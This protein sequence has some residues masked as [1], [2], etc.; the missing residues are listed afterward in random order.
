MKYLDSN[1]FIY[2]ALYKWNKAKRAREILREM[3]NGKVAI[4]SALTLSEIAQ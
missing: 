2:A 3:V 1:V 4:T